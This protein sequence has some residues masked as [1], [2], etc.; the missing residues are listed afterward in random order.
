MRKSLRQFNYREMVPA[1][2]FLATKVEESVRRLRYIL[3]VHFQLE[4]AR[5]RALRPDEDIKLVAQDTEVRSLS[6][7][8]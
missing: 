2:I 8:I 6:S 1:C 7:M 4:H 3:D 5:E